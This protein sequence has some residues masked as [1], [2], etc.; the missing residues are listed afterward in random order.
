[1]HKYQRGIREFHDRKKCIKR[2]EKDLKKDSQKIDPEDH[3]VEMKPPKC[4]MLQAEF[5]FPEVMFFSRSF[6]HLEPTLL[7][8]RAKDKR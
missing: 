6:M 4:K 2:L 8:P 1:M 5:E 3:L 7:P